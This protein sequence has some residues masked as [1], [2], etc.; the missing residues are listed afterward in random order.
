MAD[1][2]WKDIKEILKGGVDCMTQQ[3]VATVEGVFEVHLDDYERVKLL[4][5]VIMAALNAW[6]RDETGEKWKLNSKGAHKPTKAWPMPPP[7]RGPLPIE[8]VDK[9]IAWVEDDMPR[10]P[11]PAVA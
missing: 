3:R 1:I 6:E 10:D 4:H 9:F 11:P 7:P 5:A 2:Y 8:H